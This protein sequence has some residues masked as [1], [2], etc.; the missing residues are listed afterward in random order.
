MI[1]IPGGRAVTDSGPAGL[2]VV[3]SFERVLWWLFAGS[4]G[5]STRSLILSRI[6][7]E[8]RNAQQLSRDLGLDYTTVRHHLRVLEANRLV[9]AEGRRYGR[10][11][12][13]SD[14]MESHWADLETIH[15]R[16]PR[17]RVGDHE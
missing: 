5:G 8:P 15:K 13:V 4:V 14:A 17:P 10:V 7:E 1:A 16:T 6:R 9:I 11:Y 3:G 12:F 2:D